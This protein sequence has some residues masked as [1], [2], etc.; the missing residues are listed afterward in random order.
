MYIHTLV[1][2]TDVLERMPPYEHECS[3][4]GVDRPLST[5]GARYWASQGGALGDLRL[6]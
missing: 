5:D 2:E 4:H 6:P 1:E 3:V